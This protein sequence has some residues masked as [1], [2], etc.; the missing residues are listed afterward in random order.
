MSSMYCLIDPSVKLST[1]ESALLFLFRSEAPP[2]LPPALPALNLPLGFPVNGGIGAAD[3]PLSRAALLL[4]SHEPGG[5]WVPSRKHSVE[6][7]GRECM[8]RR[9]ET[10]QRQ[11]SRIP[12]IGLAGPASVQCSS[13]IRAAIQMTLRTTIEP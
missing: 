1:V 8:R 2:L 6:S 5:A 3:F 7:R 4:P 13:G 10:P 11:I 9:V 12:R